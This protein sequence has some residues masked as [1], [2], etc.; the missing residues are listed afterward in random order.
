MTPH[1]IEPVRQNPIQARPLRTNRVSNR[2]LWV[3]VLGELTIMAFIFLV[4]PAAL[5]LSKR[6]V[7]PYV[8]ISMLSLPYAWHFNTYIHRKVKEYND[9]H[10]ELEESER[11]R[12]TTSTP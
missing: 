5:Y 3:S 9:R 6:F 10:D 11:Q 2:E 4:C 12:N 8:I 7:N 1:P